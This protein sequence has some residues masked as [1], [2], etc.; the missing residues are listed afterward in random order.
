[1]SRELARRIAKI[2]AKRA[3]DPLERLSDA[4]LS[5]R[6]AEIEATF[7]AELGPAWREILQER[8]RAAGR[9]VSFAEVA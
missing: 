8:E 2:E 5:H 3:I 4:E 1:M 9:T 7:E 6:I